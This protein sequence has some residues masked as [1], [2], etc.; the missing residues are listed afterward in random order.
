MNTRLSVLFVLLLISAVGCGT[1]TSF[2][3]E[4]P[5]QTVTLAPSTAEAGTPTPPLGPSAVITLISNDVQARAFEGENFQ[6]AYLNQYIVAGGQVRSGEGSRAEISL[7]PEGTMLRI[8][9]NTLFTFEETVQVQESFFTRLFLAVG[10]IWISLSG[11]QMEVESPSGLA[12]VRGSHMSVLFDPELQSMTV[13]CLEGSCSIS[14]DLGI[15]FLT[16]G[17]AS[18]IVAENLPPNPPREM[19]EEEFQD[20][21]QFSPESLDIIDEFSTGTFA[22]TVQ[23]TELPTELPSGLPA[24]NPTGLPITTPAAV[25]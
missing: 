17:Q 20:W 13:T 6:P 3:S 14:N 4:E 19:T 18:E 5:S 24:F 21:E 9:P 7:S 2:P 22:V 10:Q 15:S 12:S 11:G 8:G 16:D 25:P 23:A 1:G